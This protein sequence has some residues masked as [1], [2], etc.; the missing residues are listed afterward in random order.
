MSIFGTILVL[1]L[2]R[3]NQKM[4][5]Y[6]LIALFGLFVSL[7]QAQNIQILNPTSTIA[8]SENDLLYLEVHF[9]NN[10]SSSMDVFAVRDVKNLV[11]GQVSYYC[12]GVTCYPPNVSVS[13][14]SLTL[15]PG[16]EDTSLKAYVDGRGVTGSSLIEYCVYNN[17]KTD[18]ACI[19]LTY[20]FGVTGIINNSH[21]G[22]VKVFPNPASSELKLAYNNANNASSSTLQISDMSGRIVFAEEV[23]AKE[24][25]VSVNVSELPAGVYV[26]N[27]LSDGLSV[28][29]DR[30]IIQ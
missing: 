13:P 4:K 6:L 5:K 21:L 2:Y 22:F 9:K 7:V 26:C 25:L 29:R 15:A 1:C 11:E 20:N 14:E 8:G 27:L 16:Q 3:K 17:A 28:A 10:S 24:G 12:F 30:V 23:Y 18:S 19:L